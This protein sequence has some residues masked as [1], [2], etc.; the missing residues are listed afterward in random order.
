MGAEEVEDESGNYQQRRN[1]L[2]VALRLVALAQLTHSLPTVY[3]QPTHSLPITV[4]VS[5]CR[6]RH[7]TYPT[8]TVRENL[9]DLLVPLLPLARVAGMPSLS[10]GM[11]KPDDFRCNR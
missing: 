2:V 6:S 7:K 8:I 9:H 11:K 1:P 10:Q 5:L 3:P 4:G